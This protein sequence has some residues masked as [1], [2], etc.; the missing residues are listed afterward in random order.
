[1]RMFRTTLA[2]A[3]AAALHLGSA[4]S[5]AQEP[6]PVR[7]GTGGPAD[8]ELGGFYQAAAE[9]LYAECGL[10][11][12]IVPGGPGTDQRAALIAGE[13]DFH[14][15][16]NLLDTLSAAGRGVPLRVVQAS[17][18]HSPRVLMAHPDA[19]YAEWDDL[20]GADAYYLSDAGFD[21]WF[22]WM[23]ADH[24]FDPSRRAPWTLDAA[25]FLA[26][27]ESAREG[28]ML[29]DPYLVERAAGWTPTLFPLADNGFDSYS[30]IAEV[31]QATLDERPDAV[32]CFVDAS[33]NGWRDYLHGDAAKAN[34]RMKAE[35]P[36]LSDGLLEFSM[37]KLR[38]SGIID[39][40]DAAVHGIGALSADRIDAFA[41]TMV[42][43]AILPADLD[44]GSVYTLDYVNAGAG[45]DPKPAQ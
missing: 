41:E 30:A 40:E 31:M 27:P 28:S 33:A 8:P 29:S 45:L 35:N 16:A 15:G 7:L 14:L 23:V 21:T 36:A 25:T 19:G 6:I 32:K 18:Q 37:E 3:L 1:M 43:A 4:A 39:G 20:L 2:A 24:G 44:I 5:L 9:G 34:E 42:E 11:L 17:F 12:E 26:D 10:E 22:R 13:L 38:T